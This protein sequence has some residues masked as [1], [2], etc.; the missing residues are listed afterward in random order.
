MSGIDQKIKSLAQK[1][2]WFIFRHGLATHALSY[3]DTILTA[4]LLPE[5]LP[6][7][8]KLAD[9]LANKPCD[10]LYSSPLARC[11]HTAEKVAEKKQIEIIQDER[12]RDYYDESHDAFKLRVA[13]FLTEAAQRENQ[14]IFICTHGIVIAALKHL[15][16]EGSFNMADELDF[17]PPASMYE[18]NGGTVTKHV[19]TP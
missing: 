1:K 7:V 11:K 13:D 12:L 9:L 10:V 16:Q 8:E 15:I 5:G 18:I 19:F 6:A 17:P 3:G 14:S 2:H 4:D